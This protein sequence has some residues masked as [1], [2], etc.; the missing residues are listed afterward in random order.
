MSA[1]TTTGWPAFRGPTG[2]GLS[3]ETNVPTRWSTTEGVEWAVDVPGRG[4]SSPIVWNGRVYVTSA[5]SSRPFKQPTPG[6]YGNDYIAELKKQGLPDD[7]VMRRVQARDNEGP[8]ESDVV[9]YMVYALD[10]RTG[11]IV[12]EREAHKGLPSGGRHRKNT[13]A[14]ETPATDGE[15]LY[16]S[17]GQNIGL[18][19]FTLDGQPLWKRQWKPTAIYLDFGTASSP[20][21]GGGQV[22]LQQDSEDD[23]V[24]GC[25]RRADR[26]RSLARSPRVRRLPEVVLVHAARVA[27]SGTRR[28][29]VDRPRD[30]SQLQRGRRQGI[31]AHRA[32]RPSPCRRR[33]RW[34]RRACCMSAS[35][36]RTARRA[37]RSSRSGQAPSATSRRR[38]ARP[39]ARSSPGVSPR[40]PA[41][42]PRQ[43]STRAASISSTTPASWASTPP[44]QVAS[45]SRRAWAASATRSRPRRW[46]PASTSTFSTKTAR[47]SSSKAATS[48]RR[49]RRTR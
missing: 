41:T 29:G 39:T 26:R 36:R 4:W 2:N 49:S 25:G 16:V 35:A 17:F 13:Y 40:R 44:I 21:V 11:A 33:R 5:I 38:R 7:E 19:C 32:C 15:R 20:V 37:G 3:S 6:L 23:V 22:F 18:F 46:P 31:V 1:S 12:W 27:A 14:S 10:A 42:R 48:T 43:W 30:D 9:R 34:S 28:A 8:E 45:C 47:P 24:S